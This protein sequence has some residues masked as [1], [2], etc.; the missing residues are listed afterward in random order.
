MNSIILTMS[1]IYIDEHGSFSAVKKLE[2]P[3]II[4]CKN[5][6]HPMNYTSRP[7]PKWI[8]LDCKSEREYKE[9]DKL[10]FL[11][12]YNPNEIHSTTTFSGMVYKLKYSEFPDARL[13]ELFAEKL[14]NAINT[15][16]GINNIDYCVS[17]PNSTGLPNKVIKNLFT[18][19]SD[20]RCDS[21]MII[22]K[23]R[24]S[25][26][27]AH[28]PSARKANV[29]G[30]FTLKDPQSVRGAKIMVLDDI[31]TTCSSMDETTKVVARESGIYVYAGAIGRNWRR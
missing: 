28:T 30:A 16:V 19:I 6:Q 9:E 24:K 17:I 25:Q 10:A 26:K 20:L 22:G 23:P 2:N 7:W 15:R 14:Y 13:Q 31:V 11:N 8:C 5:C 29:K 4:K 3:P 18:R 1:G 21:D 27:D 12:Y